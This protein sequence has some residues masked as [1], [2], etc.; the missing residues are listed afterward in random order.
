M[1]R[2]YGAQRRTFSVSQPGESASRKC[3]W[4]WC[5]RARVCLLRARS[6]SLSLHLSLHLSIHLCLS[7]SSVGGR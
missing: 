4:S 1:N 7:L 3:T 2:K 5:T 6:L